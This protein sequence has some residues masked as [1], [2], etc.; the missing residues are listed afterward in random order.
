MGNSGYQLHKACPELKAIYE[1]CDAEYWKEF[2]EGKALQ[3]PCAAEF[4][5]YRNCVE[6]VLKEKQEAFLQRKQAKQ[7][8]Q[9]K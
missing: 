8:Q 3:Q 9:E 5:N 6:L 4:N 2:R 1:K 7:Q